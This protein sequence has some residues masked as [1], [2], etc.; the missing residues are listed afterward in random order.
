MPVEARRRRSWLRR[1]RK[2]AMWAIGTR[3]Q[4]LGVP[5]A[6]QPILIKDRTAGQTLEVALGHRYVAITVSGRSYWFCRYTG[7]FIDALDAPRRED[8]SS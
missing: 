5:G 8:A 6:I 7:R 2:R 4:N 1:V 3:L